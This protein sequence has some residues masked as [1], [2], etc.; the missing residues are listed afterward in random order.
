VNAPLSQ[1][2]GPEPPQLLL[3][4]ARLGF[5]GPIPA[6]ALSSLVTQA[7]D[8]GVSAVLAWVDDD[9]GLL[10]IP[11]GYPSWLFHSLLLSSNQ[12]NTNDNRSKGGNRAKR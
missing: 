5:R 9:P 12:P 3:G 11:S 2:P 8:H 4:I 7:K 6:A 10:S 1:A